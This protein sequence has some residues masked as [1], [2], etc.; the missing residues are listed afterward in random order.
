LGQNNGSDRDNLTSR[1]SRR[2]LLRTS[3][4]LLPIAQATESRAIGRTIP[5]SVATNNE[6]NGGKPADPSLRYLAQRYP[7]ANSQPS[8]IAAITLNGQTYVYAEERG[9]DMGDYTEPQGRFIQRC[10][11]T[12]NPGLPAFTVFFRPDRSGDRTE[13]VFELGAMFDTTTPFNMPAYTV[14]ITRGDTALATVSVTKHF[15]HSRWRWQSTPRP[16]TTTVA[17]LMAS[18]MLPRYDKA[19]AGSFAT[20]T[21]P[22]RYA[23]PMDLA[24]ITAYMPSTGERDDIGL[25]TAPQAEYV[26]IGSGVALASL[27]AQLEASGTLPWHFRDERT[28]APLDVNV[29]PK[30]TMYD[31]KG[32]VPFITRTN[33]GIVLDAAHEPSLAYL[34]FML[35]GDPYALEEI[36]FAVT[37]NVVTQPFAHRG[38]WNLGGAVRAH[39]W[40]LRT[41]AHAATVTP[42]AVPAWLKPRAYFKAMLNANRD[43]ML[44]RFVNNPRPPFTTLNVMSD[45][46]GSRQADLIPADCV[47]APWQEDLEAAVLGWIVLQGHQD[48]M[49]IL[50]WKM[51]CTIAR[52]NG[53]SGWHRSS[54]V[55]YQIA[56][57][58]SK[59]SRYADDWSACWALNM[60]LQVV[61][62]NDPNQLLAGT[63]L[64]YP[65]YTLGALAIASA[66]GMAGARPCYDWLRSEI[67][68]R[69]SRSNYIGRKWSIAA[70][71]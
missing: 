67:T 58:A 64:T 7:N 71:A 35:T 63:N 5:E 13:V 70:A 33:S 1:L 28:G 47:I 49:P 10:I 2:G 36:Q 68:T 39:A 57:R 54:P 6:Q 69:M 55:P 51:K 42:D 38:S 8:L 37:F 29:Y 60:S 59:D 56:L 30:A 61:K 3:V 9:T 27:L 31:P 23:G 16:V 43:W 26:C 17:A 45:G 32:A 22:R 41:L 12:T 15:W 18:G 34:P 46:N 24:G 14:A 52:T 25:I 65:S 48:W 66:V 50:I 53:T 62:D 40:A 21:I 44:T 19:I 4:T 20:A 11:R